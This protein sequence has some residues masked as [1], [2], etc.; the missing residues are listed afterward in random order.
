MEASRA[1][2]LP[3]SQRATAVLID[4][5]AGIK[6]S[7][8]RLVAAIEKTGIAPN[9]LKSRHPNYER[10]DVAGSSNSC[11]VEAREVYV[12]YL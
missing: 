10:S 1:I 12:V 3:D 11:E 5:A 8:L 2:E 7:V 4:N 6:F 9:V